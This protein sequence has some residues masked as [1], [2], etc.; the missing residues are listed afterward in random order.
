MYL[1]VNNKATL[2]PRG[3]INWAVTK[4]DEISFAYGLH[5]QMEELRTYFSEVNNGGVMEHLNKNLGFMKSHHFVLGYN[6]KI[7]DVMRIKVEPY[8]QI[9]TNIPVYPNS[10][11]SVINITSNW[12]INKKLENTGTGQNYGIDFT[13]ERFLKKGYYYLFTAT[14]FDSKYTGGDGKEYNT[15][16][17]RGYVINLLA[18]KEWMIRKK[19]VLGVNAK[20][21]YMGGLRYTPVNYE[22]SMAVQ[23]AIPDQSKAY[24]NQF[25]S[26]LGIDLS[27][28]Y[29]MN[30]EKYTGTWYFMIKNAL[31]QPDYS[32]P[33]YSR[34]QK[35]V[36]V[37]EMRMPFPSLGYKIEF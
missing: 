37:D 23:Y 9:L 6:R 17:N 4:K 13:L 33:F 28:T 18:G 26:T 7:N 16:Y 29:K 11:F 10:S 25:P 32:D 12:A 3:G 15:V 34:M 31:M 21:T 35:D 22:Q 2:E 24:E 14:L 36:I 1:N 30:R 19:N 5:S 27:I 20:V 8:Y